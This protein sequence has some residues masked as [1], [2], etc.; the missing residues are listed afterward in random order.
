M[1]VY[2]AESLRL[3]P[4][5]GPPEC[6]HPTCGLEP[7]KGAAFGTYS[8]SPIIQVRQLAWLPEPT[9]AYLGWVPIRGIVLVRGL[10]LGLQQGGNTWE[11]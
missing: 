7:V 9:F 6:P 1:L 4:G 8:G 2:M 11:G 3:V 10:P 5:T